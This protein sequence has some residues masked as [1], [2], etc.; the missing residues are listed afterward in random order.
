MYKSWAFNKDQFK[1][2]LYND[3][4]PY[5]GE[6]RVEAGPPTPKR[7]EVVE[8]DEKLDSLTSKCK[9]CTSSVTY[10]GTSTPAT[11]KRSLTKKSFSNNKFNINKALN[12]RV[13][14]QFTA[15]PKS[16]T[17]AHNRLAFDFTIGQDLSRNVPSTNS[18]TWKELSLQD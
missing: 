14:K 7:L 4:E 16:V 13:I 17:E 1:Q 9:R 15:I 10:A 12:N 11:K 6:S 2:G 8:G 5:K 18:T 3:S